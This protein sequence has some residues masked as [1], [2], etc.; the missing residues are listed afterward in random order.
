MTDLNFQAPLS[1]D[2]SSIDFLEFAARLMLFAKPYSIVEAGTYEGAF[3][4]LAAVT[5]KLQ[6]RH[7]LVWTADVK[8]FGA[9]KLAEKNGVAD[10]VHQAQAKGIP[11]DILFT[12]DFAGTA[13]AQS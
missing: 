13:S 12:N 3:A 11:T 7:G 10:F 9:A 6:K 5:F 8:D 2:G 4:V 1:P